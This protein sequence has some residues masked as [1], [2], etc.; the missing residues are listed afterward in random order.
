METSSSWSKFQG[1]DQRSKIEESQ[2]WHAPMQDC[3][4]GEPDRE[5]NDL[6][7]CYRI[8]IQP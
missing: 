4:R 1:L 6:R 5:V 3:Q 7:I 8:S 2:K